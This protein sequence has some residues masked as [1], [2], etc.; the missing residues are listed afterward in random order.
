MKARFAALASAIAAFAV[1]PH[2]SAAPFSV[3]YQGVVAAFDVNYNVINAP[4]LD[5][6]DLFGGGDLSGDAV[7][8][9]Y[10]Y[11]TSLGIASSTVYNNGA[12]PPIDFPGPDNEL[13]GGV[14]FGASSP[15][16]AAT[17]TIN[18]HSFSYAPD[19]YADV[20]TGYG[21]F[22]FTDQGNDVFGSA[23]T[24]DSLDGSDSQVVF[25]TAAAG[26]APSTNLLGKY[27][28]A[29]FGL[30]YL[31]TPFD[32]LQN[33]DSLGF[34]LGSVSAA[35]EPSTW[36]LMISGLGLAGFALRRRAGLKPVDVQ[37]V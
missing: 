30:G 2:A 35:P 3:T 11:D 7:T 6:E 23:D 16:V 25:S 29:G 27:S 32:T 10:T 20:S 37:A 13:D 15:I 9:T 19:Y 34:V 12:T 21:V 28:S 24:A 18:G 17:F 33:S 4:V 31:D 36:A 1:A 5:V 26:N 22:D 8:A 14:A